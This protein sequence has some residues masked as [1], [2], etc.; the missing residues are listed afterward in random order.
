MSEKNYLPVNLIIIAG[1]IFIFGAFSL[2]GLVSNVFDRIERMIA[3]PGQLDLLFYGGL[4]LDVLIYGA[5]VII[6]FWIGSLLLQTKPDSLKA[7]R[8]ILW[9]TL[10]FAGIGLVG[11]IIAII[12]QDHD[13]AGIEYDSR[14]EFI[15]SAS[16]YIIY[17]LAV[18]IVSTWGIRSLKQESIRNLFDS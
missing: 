3:E 1:Y 4:L 5:G 15:A 16:K 9:V 12:F 10:V 11:I 7:A 8:A 17:R 2:D 6:F 14:P 18:I 13:F